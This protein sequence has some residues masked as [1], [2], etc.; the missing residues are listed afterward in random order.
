ME[1]MGIEGEQTANTNTKNQR[2]IFVNAVV[3]AGGFGSRLKPLTDF[4][5]KPMLPVANVPMLDYVI[6]HL[7]R[8]GISDIVL[9]L[10]YYPEQIVEWTKG[11]TDISP[12]YYVE[13]VPLGTAGGVR[14]AGSMLDERFI[15]VS[16]DALENI[17]YAAM[18]ESHMRSGKLVTMAVTDVEDARPFGL[19]HFDKN[20][21][22]TELTE[23]PT[24]LCEGIVNCGVY[25]MERKAL[26][27]I[28]HGVKYDFSRDLFPRLIRM[29]Q[30]NA[31][32][33]NGYWSDVGSMGSYYAANFHMLGGSFFPPCANK[34][35]T[36]SHRF[37]SDNPSLAAY[38]ALVT[39][40]CSGSIVG[41]N[42]AVASGASISG[43]IVLP[44][45][46]VRE[47]HYN[48][49]IGAGYSIPMVPTVAENP[50][51]STQI[52]KNFS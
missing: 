14:A 6:S 19:V 11:Y 21:A 3:L 4:M 52:Y 39:G 25:I 30:V 51:V 2:G 36:V 10:G 45:V 5:P 12:R 31:H 49:I 43:C 28:P 42:A 37:G 41:N 32:Y 29:G 35:R 17:D 47:R 24:R 46:T 48:E 27:Q 20:G 38:S 8:F 9:T 33:H 44:N 16:G 13:N 40:R 34:L 23:K 18:L 1:S 22:V 15:I 26:S 50:H 7:Y